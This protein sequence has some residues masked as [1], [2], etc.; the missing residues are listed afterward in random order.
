MLTSA[1]GER[2]RTKAVV[3]QSILPCIASRGTEDVAECLAAF[4]RKMWKWLSRRMQHEEDLTVLVGLVHGL[5]EH[6][7]I[8]KV[9]FEDPLLWETLLVSM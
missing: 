4:A 5:R 6:R 1:E 3:L 2:P 8:L 7:G 9:V